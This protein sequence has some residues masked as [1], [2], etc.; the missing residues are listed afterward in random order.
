MA[1]V[2]LPARP[3]TPLGRL[4]WALADGLTIVGRDLG[5]LRRAP[6][7]I[8]AE[9]AFPIVMVLLFG[10]VFGSAIPIPGGGNYREFLLPGLFGMTAMAGVAVTG[11]A[12]AGDIRRGVMDRF[13]SLPIARLAVP[14]G[15]TGAGILG[16][17]LS[18]GLMAGCGLAAGWRVRTGAGHALAGFGLVLLAQYAV[19]W[20][21]VYLGLTVPDEE[22]ADRLSILFLPVSMVANTFVPTTGM[23]AWLRVVADWNP[24]SA[25]V[26]ACRQ[27]FGNPA[28]VAAHPALPLAHPV[29]A[30]LAW[31]AVLLA[32]F[33]PL[34]V[35]R[36][37]RG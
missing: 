5:H 21:G 18:L 24:V 22:T 2:S 27:L 15:Q 11:Q 14:F 29:A 25:I 3:V 26:A 16:G 37:G 35:R 13:R 30:T 34:S 6:G 33:V 23:P 9:L 17:A 7:R 10:Y 36:F 31:S 32:V 12:V 8:V 4:R 19:S 20:V 1:A 28:P